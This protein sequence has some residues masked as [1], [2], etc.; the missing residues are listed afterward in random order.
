[1]LSIFNGCLLRHPFTCN[2]FL[3]HILLVLCLYSQNLNNMLKLEG[4]CLFALCLMTFVNAIKYCMHML[5]KLFKRKERIDID[6]KL[7]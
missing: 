2:S 1:M 4:N 7:M 5:K 6:Y 3:G